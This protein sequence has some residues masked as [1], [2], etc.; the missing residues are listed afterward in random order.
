[1]TTDP[2]VITELRDPFRS[3]AAP[4]RLVRHIIARHG[5]GPQ[6]GRLVRAYFREAFCVPMFRASAD[7]LT[8]P[9][10]QLPFVGVNAAVIHQI[11]ARRAE[12]DATD[13]GR[14]PERTAPDVSRNATGG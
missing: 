9:A 14:L 3:G 11:V 2:Q 8:L 5:E 13:E 10:E 4:S 12:W 6:L 1:M 7:L